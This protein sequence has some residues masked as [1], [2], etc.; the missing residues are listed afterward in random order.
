MGAVT[1]TPDS[2]PDVTLLKAEAAR[3]GLPAV[4]LPQD[5]EPDPKVV[6]C[7]VAWPAEPPLI[8]DV[9][10]LFESL[11]VRVARHASAGAADHFDL[12]GWS[13]TV[14]DSADL[15]C[16]ALA[17][18]HS[19][20]AER[21]GLNRLVV[22]ERLTW[23][24]V[25]LL[26][27]MCRYIRQAG[28][29]L[30]LE[31][32]EQTLLRNGEFV[33][34]LLAFFDARFEPSGASAV[35]ED[36]L[37]QRLRSLLDQVTGLDEDRVLRALLEVA[38]A[39]MRT[40]FYQVDEQGKPRP[41]LTLKI[42]P[43]RLTF[44]AAPKPLVETYVYSP[45][46]EGLHLRAGRV[47][48][49]GLR[50]SDRAEDFRA[51]VLG[52]MKAQAVKNSVI[53]PAGAKGAF[54]VR[55]SLAGLDRAAAHGAVRECY[56]TFVRGL[57]DVTDNLV[58]GQVVPP[59]GVRR[60][61]GAD[62]YLVVA[63]DK[64][65]ATFSDLANSVAAEYDFWLGDAFA[66]GGSSGY[67]H[68]RMGITARGAWVSVKA[69]L[70]EMGFDMDRDDFTVV[71]IGDMSGD[72]FGN[73][74]L[75]SDRIRL[76]AAFDHRH[77][78]LDPDP[79]PAVSS[80]ERARLFAL[81]S[82]SWRDYDSGLISRGG[83]V[84][85][86]HVKRVPLSP[87]VRARL[88]ITEERD[89]TTP[90]D[91]VRAILTAPV[92]LL[93]NGGIGTYVKASTESHA[94]VGDKANDL[95]RVDGNSLRCRVVGE[96]GNLGL[97]QRARIE[98]GLNGGRVNADFIDNSAGVDTSDHEV[99][100]KVLLDAGLASGRVRHEDRDA[101]LA[102]MADDV[103]DAVL[104]DNRLQALAISL[105]EWQGPLALDRH[106]RLI[107]FL[108]STAGLDRRIEQLPGEDEISDRRARGVGLTRPEIAVLLAWS[109]ISVRDELLGCALSE[110]PALEPVIRSYFP[111]PAQIPELI[112]QHPLGR[113]IAATVLANDVVNQAGPGFLYRLEERTGA[114]LPDVA[115]AFTVARRVFGI[116]TLWKALSDEAEGL[117]AEGQLQALRDLQLMLERASA[118]LLRNRRRPLAIQDELARLTDAVAEIRDALDD[119]LDE[120]QRRS[121]DQTTDALVAF[122]MRTELARRVAESASLIAA[123]DIVEAA[124][125]AGTDLRTMAAL[126]FAVGGELQLEWLRA[127]AAEEP[128]D[129]HWTSMAKASLS[130]DLLV[131]QRRLAVAAEQFADPAGDARAAVSRWLEANR[132]HARGHVVLLEELRAAA[133]VDVAMLTI[134]VQQLRELA[135]TSL[136][137]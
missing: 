32:V 106:A 57:L 42:E 8:A 30:S 34:T 83:G 10:P 74:M 50:W 129:S 15:F 27:A 43:A 38:A 116:D 54:V 62:A 35:D 4:W 66:S 124:T 112:A 96:G 20:A 81:P 105:A 61:D 3:T 137:P 68:K 63:A 41:R 80:A 126:Y 51:E 9:V 111:A 94:D 1:T 36:D 71:G 104:T 92:T 24:Q 87:Q 127:Q 17:A 125:T 101:V 100:L 78:F 23:R 93:W 13:G 33:R 73:G 108:E 135:Q 95:V 75:L 123:L 128:G 97:T 58:D 14:E 55:R 118:W 110:D 40:S 130:D 39:T 11:G 82:S 60:H 77:I 59:P 84:Y 65:T 109:K 31:Y 89:W 72:V 48:R 52:L 45:V 102:S 119:T 25:M 29:S 98:Y 7:V 136:H 5:S 21:D 91:L 76:I 131:Q 22:V 99:N 79:D 12:L 90:D 53:V 122:G 19:G 47:A 132:E 117:R 46:V 18:V 85:A 114:Q 133:G 70:R 115:A 86:R 64:G 37:G 2:S 103:A 121:L 120:A 49:G 28:V 56:A 44:V 6:Q 26:R 67:D 113:E 16:P 69:H 88:G 107:A 134:A